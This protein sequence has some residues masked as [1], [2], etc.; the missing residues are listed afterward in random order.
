MLDFLNRMFS[1][2]GGNS[3]N[4]AKERLRLVLVHDRSSVSPEIM[5]AL[6]ED[7]IKVISSYLEIDERSL[8]VNL[9]NDEASVALVAN[10]P[11]LGLKRRNV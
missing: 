6:K 2:D 7:L 9:N 4:I 8:E 5:E 1:R 11:V 3:K 10:I